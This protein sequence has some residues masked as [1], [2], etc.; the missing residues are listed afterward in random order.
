MRRMKEKKQGGHEG[1]GRHGRGGRKK[2]NTIEF[3]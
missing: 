3:L 2:T 1:N